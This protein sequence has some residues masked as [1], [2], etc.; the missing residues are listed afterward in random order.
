MSSEN[1]FFPILITRR[2][3]LPLIDVSIN[4]KKIVFLNRE[5][6]VVGNKKKGIL[7]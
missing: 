6:G 5:D 2:R 1:I 7:M 3:T 4:H